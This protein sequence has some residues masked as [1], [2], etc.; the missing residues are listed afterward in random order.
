M[1]G[2][3]FYNQN[4]F[5]GVFDL[6]YETRFRMYDNEYSWLDTGKYKTEK[7]KG[8]YTGTNV[9]EINYLYNWIRPSLSGS[10]S[11]DKV[12]LKFRMN[13]AN[14]F[15]STDTTASRI[16]TA[17][18]TGKEGK[19][20]T[21]AHTDVS[22]YTFTPTFD[23]AMQYKVVPDKLTLNTG[24]RVSPATITATTTKGEVYGT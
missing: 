2:Y 15:T 21:T 4:G 18:D 24:A 7:I 5:K 6:D 8:I 22:T 3:T 11:Q 14:T 9:S 10:W 13:L 12:A 1:G 23:L 19:L 16:G 17:A 20:I